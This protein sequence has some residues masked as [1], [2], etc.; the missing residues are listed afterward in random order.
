[1]QEITTPAIAQPFPR[2]LSDFL[3][4]LNATELQTSPETAKAQN[5]TNNIPV[6]Y[7]QKNEVLIICNTKIAG[8][9]KESTKPAVA[10]GFEYLPST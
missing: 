8:A 10:K 6:E 9:I 4:L 1:M 2:I 5:N 7:S 3:A